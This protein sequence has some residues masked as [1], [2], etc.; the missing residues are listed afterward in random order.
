MNNAI[1]IA[2]GTDKNYVQ[3][4]AVMLCSLF[5]NNKDASFNVYIL[6][7]A[8][9]NITKTFFDFVNSYGH[10]VS[11]I[12]IDTDEIKKLPLRFNHTHAVYYRMFLPD[13]LPRELDKVIYFDTDIAINGNISELW[14][15]DLGG[16]HLAAITNPMRT[17]AELRQLKEVIQVRDGEYF[18]SGVLV[19][20]LN[21]LRDERFSKKCFIWAK[22]NFN[23]IMYCDQDVM[24]AVVA[25]N[26][27]SLPLKYN[28]GHAMIEPYLFLN[29]YWTKHEVLEARKAPVI[30]HY[31]GPC[32]AWHYKCR[33]KYKYINKYFEY[34]KKTPWRDFKYKDKNIF[35][36]IEKHIINNLRGI[37]GKTLLMID[38]LN[39]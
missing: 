12:L 28:L 31:I 10:K 19:L 36:F 4:A 32:K 30:I 35:S 1:S 24:N 26:W 22:N 18:N 34:I 37:I 13:L 7:E 21:K 3:H 16:N 9:E 23:K 14:E 33:Y 25:G 15:I 17:K 29:T 11:I 8:E 20:N 5:E 39:Y 27:L 6:T 38:D 2:C